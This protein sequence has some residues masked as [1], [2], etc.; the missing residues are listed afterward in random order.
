M[1]NR[2]RLRFA[3]QGLT[4][5]DVIHCL[6][7]G[8][9]ISTQ[10][11]SRRQMEDAIYVLPQTHHELLEEAAWRSKRLG[12]NAVTCPL[13][14]ATDPSGVPPGNDGFFEDYRR[15]RICKFIDTTGNDALRTCLREFVRVVCAGRFRAGETEK[16]RLTD[17]E[18][19]QRI[20]HTRLETVESTIYTLTASMFMLPYLSIDKIRSI[21]TYKYVMHR[22]T[23][24]L[25][26][27][28]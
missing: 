17:L 11:R 2:D 1:E 27:P 8:S 15:D 21:N 26:T 22:E 4:M 12:T 7:E 5:Q 10:K 23:P 24:S 28:E 20:F 25:E 3:I 18:A 16:V 13:E 9:L 14:P 19:K 6:P